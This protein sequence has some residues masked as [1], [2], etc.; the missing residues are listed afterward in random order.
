MSMVSGDGVH[1]SD[2]VW[3]GVTGDRSSAFYNPFRKKWVYSLR[4]SWRARSR[5]YWEYDDFLE[6]AWWET[7]EPVIW[8]AADNQDPPDPEIG[9]PAQL[10]NLDAVSYESIMLGIFEIHLGPPNDVCSKQ[11]LPKI[12]ELNL[13]YSRDGFHWHRPDRRA[14]IRAERRD[15]WD[16]GYVQ[17]VGGICTIH[18]DKL[19]FYYTGFQGDVNKKSNPFLQDGM[20]DR[21]STG[22][23]F[24]RR[25][26]FVSMDAG[27]KPV[28]LLTRPVSFQ[29]RC[30][31]VNADVDGGEL[32]AEIAN[33]SGEVIE[34]FSLES[35]EAVHSDSTIQRIT[36][37]PDRDLSSLTGQS[38]RFR[39]RMTKGSLYAF[40][41]SKDETGRSDGYVAAG[42]PGYTGPIDTVGKEAL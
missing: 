19:W 28:E 2:P 30:L 22:V 31:F 7:G 17:P 9:Q 11:G 15:V 25:D 42:G 40:W 4:D 12:T 13:A 35:C 6:G 38:V 36:W 24:L 34:P 1:W 29:G 14:F 23:A 33:K 3:T 32:R 41:V 37:K 16:R 21:G 26:G 5:R 18:G 39:F 27:H 10:Y 20:Y 8:C